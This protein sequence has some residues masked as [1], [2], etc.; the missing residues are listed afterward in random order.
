MC[1]S[2]A[3]LLLCGP[4]DGYGVP[5]TSHKTRVRLCLCLITLGYQFVLESCSAT[6]FWTQRQVRHSLYHYFGTWNCIPYCVRAVIT[7]LIW[8]IMCHQSHAVLAAP[9]L[10]HLWVYIYILCT[11]LCILQKYICSQFQKRVQ[12]K[13]GR[14]T[15]HMLLVQDEPRTRICLRITFLLLQDTLALRY[16]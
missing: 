16:K 1:W 10:L 7:L 11:Y 2:H 6:P 3:A 5:C 15:H 13:Y 4:R 9:T 14:Y 12:Q 8:G